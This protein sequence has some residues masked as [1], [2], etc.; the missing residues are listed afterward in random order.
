M[1]RKTRRAEKYRPH[2]VAQTV[3]AH[4]RPIA[5]I[6][7]ERA[8]ETVAKIDA[9]VPLPLVARGPSKADRKA[10]R[11]KAR[12]RAKS[13]RPNAEL[14]LSTA[15]LVAAGAAFERT[16]RVMGTP[17]GNANTVALYLLEDWMNGLPGA[18]IVDGR[19]MLNWPDIPRDGGNCFP[20]EVE[21]SPLPG[22]GFPQAKVPAPT[23]AAQ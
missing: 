13:F 18:L 9:A 11:A 8:A 7:P 16:L 1:S 15:P 10:I 20:G 3:H 14:R 17:V 19:L 22:S 12:A 23:A 6:T 5:H 2:T 4:G 21:L